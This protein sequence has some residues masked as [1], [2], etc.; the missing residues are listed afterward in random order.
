[1]KIKSPL[2][3]YPFEF[4][5]IER[6][7]GGL[8]VVGTV[9]GIESSVLFDR[10]DLATLG[11]RVGPPLLAAAA[12]LVVYRAGGGFRSAPRRLA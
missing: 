4:S 7:E 5:R 9:A 8:A 11:R 3:E 1:M 2:G 12:L 6:R 10:D